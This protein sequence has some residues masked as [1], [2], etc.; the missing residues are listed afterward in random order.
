MSKLNDHLTL[1]AN[2][3]VVAGIIFLAVQMAQNTRAVQSMTRDSIA[4]KQMEYYGWLA[5]NRELAEVVVT[6]TATGV[7]HLDPV[8][9]RMWTGFAVA[10]LR[11]WENSHYQYQRGLFSA[12]E[13]EGRVANMRAMI[14]TPGFRWVWRNERDKFSAAFRDVIDGFLAE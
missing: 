10:A 7:D 13:Y 6:A 4:E 8:E 11:E 3:A 1:A 14:N 2:L 9:Q 12:V 5:N